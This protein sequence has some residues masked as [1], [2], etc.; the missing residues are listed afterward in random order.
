MAEGDDV[1]QIVA[2]AVK[3]AELRFKVDADGR[4]NLLQPIEVWDDRTFPRFLVVKTR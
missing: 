2:L 1:F 3:L 4:E